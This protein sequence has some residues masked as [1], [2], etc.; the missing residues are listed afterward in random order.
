[1]HDSL[2]SCL[3]TETDIAGGEHWNT[4][5]GV[6]NVSYVNAVPAFLGLEELFVPGSEFVNVL[7]CAAMEQL[8][9]TGA[10]YVKYGGIS[11]LEET[12]LHRFTISPSGFCLHFDARTVDSGPVQ[13]LLPWSRLE[14][15]VDRNGPLA[16][17]LS[18]KR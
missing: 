14:S 10:E 12:E 8:R 17:I 4:R 9:L 13:V 3:V 1:V 11:E 6:I 16:P 7:S 15:V 2:I 5:Y 18:K